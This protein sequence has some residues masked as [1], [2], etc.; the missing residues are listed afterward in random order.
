MSVEGADKKQHIP[1]NNSWNESRENAENISPDGLPKHSPDGNE[2][3]MAV[4]YPLHWKVG[5]VYNNGGKKDFYHGRS[6]DISLSGASVFVDQNIAL[7]DL[8]V[9]L[10]VPP[11]NAGMKEA[12]IEIQCR[13]IYTVFDN[14]KNNFRLGIFFLKFKGVGKVILSNILDKKVSYPALPD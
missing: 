13:K 8:V 7:T 1:D 6:Q 9:L 5:L 10:V 11:Q 3:R 2:K 12:V 14:K 4:R